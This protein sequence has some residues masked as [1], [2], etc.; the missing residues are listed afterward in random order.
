[1]IQS[2]TRDI[3]SRTLG[4]SQ[5]TI[6]PPETG[7]EY[8]Q[9]SPAMKYASSLRGPHPA[10]VSNIPWCITNVSQVRFI[11]FACPGLEDERIVH[12]GRSFKRGLVIPVFPSSPPPSPPSPPSLPLTIYTTHLYDNELPGSND[13]RCAQQ[14]F[15]RR[16]S[17]QP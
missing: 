9:A 3:S 11:A 16:W 1:M 14:P 4:S 12:A 8:L 5:L 13:V 2:H 6:S 17:S 15:F 10:R 7:D